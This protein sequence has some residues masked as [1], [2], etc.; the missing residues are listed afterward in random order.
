MK[1]RSFVF[2][3]DFFGTKNKTRK[4]LRD[5]AAILYI[6]KL[7]YKKIHHITKVRRLN[8]K[9]KKNKQT[10]YLAR[11]W[12]TREINELGLDQES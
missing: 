2:V 3:N 11:V 10:S 7:R 8:K 12:V 4:L 6:I 9:K 1:C 5:W